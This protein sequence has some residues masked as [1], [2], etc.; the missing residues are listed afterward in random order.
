VIGIELLA[1][2]QGIDFH[3]PLKTSAILEEI[4]AK[5]RGQVAYYDRDR[6]FA[7]D[8]EAI[9]EI[10]T[11]LTPHLAHLLPSWSDA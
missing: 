3:R 4:H 8:L 10:M 9:D 5:V 7:H 11:S 6:Y 2:A 1:A